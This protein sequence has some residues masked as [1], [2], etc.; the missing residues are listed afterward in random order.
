MLCTSMHFQRNV[1]ASH[2]KALQMNYNSILKEIFLILATISE[3]ILEARN[4]KK[5]TY[6]A[7]LS[8]N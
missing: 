2:Y 5:S 7:I 3:Y 4:S 6:F 1:S 8:N